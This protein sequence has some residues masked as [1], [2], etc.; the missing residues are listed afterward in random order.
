MR[1]NYFHCGLALASIGVST[2]F[3]ATPPEH[4]KVSISPAT[5]VA[6]FVRSADGGMIALERDHEHTPQAFLTTYGD[7]FGIIDFDKQLTVTRTIRDSMG[8]THTS[9]DQTHEGIPVFAGV[10]RIHQNDRGE[11]VAAN[12][13]FVPGIDVDLDPT[14]A[15]DAAARTALTEVRDHHGTAAPMK[16]TSNKIVVYRSNLARGIPGTNHL[17][18]QVEVFDG[19]GIRD[20]V[21][22]DAHT[23]A[24]IDRL[25]TVCTLDRQVYDGGTDPGSLVWNEGDATPFGD[26][27][28]DAMIDYSEDTYNLYASG[29]DSAYLSFDGSDGTMHAV[30]NNVGNCPNA[31]WNGFS[32][33]Y[34]AGVTPDDVVSHEWT[35][36]YTQFTSGLIYAWQP[37]ALNESY[38]DI[39]GE[40]VDLLNG[41]GLDSPGP[42]RLADECSTFGAS[43]PP[44]F[45]I[46]S[47]GGIAGPFSAAGANF[48]P[49]PPLSVTDDVEYADD[50]DDQG[51]TTSTTDGCE[52]LVGFTPGRIA[53]IDRGTCPFVNKVANAEAA[54][55][56]GVIIVNNV[57][58]NPFSMGGSG[59]P[60]IP[61]V[62]VSQADG[63][64]L[65]ANPL[66]LNATITL[67]AAADAS[68]RW[69]TGEDSTGFGGAIRDM[70]NPTCFGDPGKV[71]DDIYFCSTADSGGVHSNSG[72][73]NHAFALVVDGG[74]Y[75]GQTITAVGL[76][77]AFHIYWRAQS[78]Y[79]VPTT[80]F[81]D[82]ADALEQSCADLIGAPL[83]ALST[84]STTGVVSGEVITFGDCNE[85]SDAIAAVEFRTHP[86]QCGFTSMLAPDAPNPCPP[87]N[88]AVTLLSQNFEFGLGG[89][90]T[91]TRDIVDPAT[92]DTPDWAIVSSLPDSEP[93][94]AAF[95]PNLIIGNCADDLESG[96]L[97]LES[98]AVVLPIDANELRLRFDH[99]VATE[100]AW[101]G[102]NVKISVNNGPW[103]LLASPDFL[104]NAYPTT[105]NGSDN[106]M[107]GEE[108]FTGTDGGALG[109]SWGQ[110]QIDFSAHASPGDS[111]A[112]RFELGLDG[113][114][115]NQGWYVDDVVVYD[116]TS[117]LD[118]DEDGFGDPGDSECPGGVATDCDDQDPNNFPGNIEI[119]DAQDNDCN[120]VEDCSLHADVVAPS[121]L[122]DLNDMVFVLDA[123]ADSNPAINYPGSD[124][125]PCGT[126]NGMVDL[127]D[128]LD[129]LDA[130]SGN[131]HCADS[132]P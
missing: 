24:V 110:S 11:I 43:L 127:D 108:A 26:V 10:I 48:N 66:S 91:G 79:Q 75:N 35:H 31:N 119:C 53:M 7:L 111:V 121:C 120:G 84:E 124:L 39:F 90:T 50:G 27:D 96:V 78:V 100:S 38:S 70:W 130:F 89:W 51:G 19:F 41:A 62:M 122:I 2:L 112:F 115:G 37:G 71:T 55:A 61:S 34:C 54:G 85:V 22:V 16:I 81:S 68:Y 67:V 9:F 30:V 36:A 29:T 129:V 104:F 73:S 132:C 123:F 97:F 15:A 60:T 32:T 113:C 94:S 12:G 87:G 64:T 46:N 77:K 40:I 33:N 95:V 98:P 105:L 23:L 116:C 56:T 14:A 25:P 49:S 72:V 6:R 117:C 45:T 103:T 17:A 102:G 47:P 59:S 99:W 58:G 118:G 76:T 44:E 74:T 80:D 107:G 57:E 28:I 82:H 88:A 42:A 83:F 101:D 4:L 93:G 69:L 18:Y 131:P 65:K 92:F 3:A 1:M 63:D 86:D 126:G 5:G 109:G 21:F 106:P 13:T 52:L 125:V 8:W 20:H 114:N 128:V